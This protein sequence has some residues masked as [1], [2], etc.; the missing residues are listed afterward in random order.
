MT[1]LLTKIAKI[2]VD[3]LWCI[4][5]HQFLIE[6]FWGYFMIALGKFWAFFIQ[7]LVTLLATYLGTFLMDIFAVGTSYSWKEG[8]RTF[9]SFCEECF[10][11]HT[12]NRFKN[13]VKSPIPWKQNVA[14]FSGQSYKGCSDRK[15]R[16][17]ISIHNDLE[18]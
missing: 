17:K 12:K 18:S 1:K 5:N 4:V 6:N 14:E 8:C 10:T 7:H 2:N 11:V 13:S 16:I 9:L 3:C 15:L